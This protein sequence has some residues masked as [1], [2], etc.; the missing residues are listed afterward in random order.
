MTL[1]AGIVGTARTSVGEYPGSSDLGYTLV[2][3]HPGAFGALFQLWKQFLF[4]IQGIQG[5]NLYANI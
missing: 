5:V 2:S 3:S 1:R 4:H